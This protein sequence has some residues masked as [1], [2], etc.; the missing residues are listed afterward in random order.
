SIL[1]SPATYDPSFKGPLE[2]RSCTDVLCLLLFIVFLVCWALIGFLALTKGNIS[3]LI[4][5]KDS[6]GN[7]CGVDSDVIDRPYLVFF[8]LT[9]CISRDVLTTG[10]P[11]K[12]VC[13]SQC[14]EVFFSFSLNASSNGNY[15]RSYMIC[16]GGVQP[17]NY[18][19]AVSWVAQSKCA[20]WYL[21]SK[22]GK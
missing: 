14:P 22:S 16:E 8:D 19:L 11:T 1:G 10:C 9:R 15:N 4:N 17:N 2:R 6:N 5:P 13:V 7:I 21:P 3:V 20:S 18:A 12:Q